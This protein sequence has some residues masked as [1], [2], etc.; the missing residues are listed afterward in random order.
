LWREV[1]KEGGCPRGWGGFR[2]F[3]GFF[4]NNLHK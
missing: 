2:E 3:L 1:K 4:D